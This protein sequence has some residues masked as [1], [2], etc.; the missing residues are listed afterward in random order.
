MPIM[1]NSFKFKFLKK[2][3]GGEN[4]ENTTPAFDN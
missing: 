4:K 2:K 1:F 3:G